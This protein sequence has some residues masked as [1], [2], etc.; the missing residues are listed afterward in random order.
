MKI[1]VTGKSGQLARSLVER[2]NGLPGIELVTVGRPEM[3]LEDPES[4]GRS[5]GFARPDVVISTA[6][7]TAVDR[8]EDE[9]VLAYRINAIGAEAVASAAQSI[10]AT[11]IHLSTDY[12][13]SGDSPRAYDED[14][15]PSPRTVYG[16][17]KLNGERGVARANPRHII[18]R[19][20]WVY[21]PFG[22]NFVKTMLKLASD[23]PSVDVV[24]DQWGNPTSALD[25]ATLIL[26]IAAH[27]IDGKYG[28]YHL[29]GNGDATWA[30]LARYVFEISRAHGGPSAK[31]NDIPAA[32][33]P[34]TAIRPMNSRL[35]CTKAR[36]TFG[37]EMGDWRLSVDDV[38]QRLVRT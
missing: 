6:A 8:A 16:L 20:S 3:D 26:W 2:S 22:R 4:I 11:I 23:C 9:P 5:I 13:F 36:D 32:S 33:Y 1:L 30:D 29:A 10:G 37:L 35:S 12:V 25:L 31:V 19:T 18:L 17:T 14:D 38:V 15:E 34:A 28:T 7:Y 24:S 21:S 27:D